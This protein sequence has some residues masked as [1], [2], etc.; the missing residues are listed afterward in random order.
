M[1]NF[2]ESRPPVCRASSASERVDLTCRGKGKRSFH[3]CGDDKTVEVVLCTIISVNQLSIYGAAADMCG[4]LA[5]R[6][7]DCSESTG[8][9]VVQDNPETKIIPTELITTI[10][11]RRTD[12]NVQGNL[13]KLSEQKI[14]NL[15][16][17]LQLIKP[18]CNVGITKTVA[19]RQYFTTFGDAELNNLGRSCREYTLPRS[20][21]LSKVKGWIH[22]NTK[23]GHG[24]CGIEVVIQSLSGDGTRSWVMIV[25][26]TN[27]YV[28]EM[29][30]KTQDDHIDCIGE[31]T[32]KPVAK[33]RP[34]QT[35][36]LFFFPTITLPHNQRDCIDVEPGPFDK[37]LFRIASTRCFKILAQMFRSKF[38][39]SSSWSNRTWLL[40][41]R[42][43]PERR[44]QYRVDPFNAD[45]IRYLR[46]IQGYSGGKRI[47]PTLQDNVL[48]PDN[49]AEHIY[50]I[51]SSH[52]M[53]SIIQSGLIPGGK[54][55]RKNACGVL[56]GRESNVHR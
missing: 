53:H 26:G 2:S 40:H 8:K 24:R 23:I 25:N 51:G 50:H 20:D 54:K 3:F 48:L 28:T 35:S 27:K 31:R 42:G 4:E 47:N 1:L 21:L 38:A 52:D 34:K 5:C 22:G 29:T 10:K 32:G 15:P 56:Y 7:S 12:E 41:R 30:E 36:K 37:K 46:A 39:S 18:C 11:S 6:I 43:G 44:F 9:L 33:A 49:F 16:Y 17:H 14:A 19:R 55:T 13:L 45:T